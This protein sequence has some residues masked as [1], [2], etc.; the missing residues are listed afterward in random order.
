MFSVYRGNLPNTQR[1]NRFQQEDEGQEELLY[2]E[3]AVTPVEEV[4]QYPQN[5][6]VIHDSRPTEETQTQSAEE[7]RTQDTVETQVESAV[8]TSTKAFGETQFRGVQSP[9]ETHFQSQMQSTE[10]ITLLGI[11]DKHFFFQNLKFIWFCYE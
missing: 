9:K 5:L 6:Q 4:T 10:E 3:A 2:A 7:I 1:G 8:E 11:A